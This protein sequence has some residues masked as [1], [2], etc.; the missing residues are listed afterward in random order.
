MPS[1][2]GTDVDCGGFVGQYIASALNKSLVTMADVDERLKKLFRVRMRLG[3]FDPAGALQAIP[4]STIC[5]PAAQALSRDGV[6]QAAVLLKSAFCPRRSLC[7]AALAQHCF[8]AQV[9]YLQR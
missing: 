6:A 2:T 8:V 9:G 1:C 3:H 7:H 5:S 4:P